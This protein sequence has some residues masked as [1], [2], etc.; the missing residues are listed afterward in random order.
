VALFVV[1]DIVTVAPSPLGQAAGAGRVMTCAPVQ[2]SFAGWA[3]TKTFRS[4][5]GNKRNNV[6]KINSV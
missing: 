2:L 6:F 1:P 4:K 3:K 5:K